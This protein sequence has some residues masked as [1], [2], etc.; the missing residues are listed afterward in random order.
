MGL[1]YLERHFQRLL[2]TIP[3][4]GLRFDLQPLL[5]AYTLNTISEM[6][7]GVCVDDLNYN[8][9]DMQRFHEAEKCMRIKGLRAVHLSTLSNTAARLY[10]SDDLI[11]S[12]EVFHQFVADMVSKSVEK[13]QSLEKGARYSLLHDS[14]ERT[15]D[16]Q[17][18][19]DE[20]TNLLFA[21]RDTGA[22][23]MSN[24]FFTL[25]R[26]PDLWS[27]LHG[28]VSQLN[29]RLPSYEDLKSM[30]FLNNIIK[31][32][33]F[34]RI[35][36]FH[37]GLRRAIANRLFPVVPFNYREALVD[38]TIPMGGGPDGTTPLF[39]GKGTYVMYCTYAM[40]RD[41]AVYGADALDFNPDRWDVPHLRPG[42]A[43]VPFNGGPRTCI[44]RK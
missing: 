1:E 37:I 39:V 32:G 9:S 23:L 35:L 7:F 43:Y 25:S 11:K 17:R 26:R 29:G 31:E 24:I 3:A 8:D 15:G 18:A 20:A 44:G 42:W 2:K 34:L 21:G 4:D 22:V 13:Y 41:T 40:H 10:R 33:K 36:L 28:E 38:T 30:R 19:K 16:V 12:A 5:F 6:L 27:R 14:M